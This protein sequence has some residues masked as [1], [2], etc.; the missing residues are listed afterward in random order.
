MG[1]R[2]RERKAEPPSG[3]LGSLVKDSTAE[4][5]LTA[6]GA[7][8][9][10]GSFSFSK[11]HHITATH[12]KKPVEGG[13]RKRKQPSFLFNSSILLHCGK[14]KEEETRARFTWNDPN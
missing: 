7:L 4:Q 8:I 14:K 3:G 9:P 10:V 12:D 13:G 2:E 5:M 1:A 11:L 6:T